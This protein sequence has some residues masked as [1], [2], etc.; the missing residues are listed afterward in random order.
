MRTVDDFAHIRRLHRDGLSMRQ[1]ARQLGVGRDTVRKALEHPEP[2]PYTLSAPRTAPTFG[3]FRAIVDAILDA[4]AHAPRK[5][6]HTA[7]QIF[8]RLVAEYQYTGGYDHVRRHLKHRRLAARDTFVPLDHRPGHRCEADF[9]HIHVD[10][11]DGRRL[12]PVLVMTWS[13]SNAPFALA[14]PTERTEAILHGMT[15]AFTFFGV[16]APRGVVGQPD[17]GGHPHRPR[18]GPHP[19][20]AVRRPR[21][22][23]FTFTPTFCLPVTPAGEA[24]R[25]EPGEGLAADVGHPGAA[26][27]RPGRAERPPATVRCHWRP[28]TAPAGRTR[29]RWAPASLATWPRPCLCRAAR[30]RR[31]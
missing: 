22:S 19:A 14:L 15:E 10:F 12:V 16:R 21:V 3:P 9:G 26:G 4:D 7:S 18:A 23:H 27:E 11:P 5:Q 30:S 17:D 20:P 8:R 24:P 31:A 6:R 29:R 25:R 28:V 1:I 13:H 2:T